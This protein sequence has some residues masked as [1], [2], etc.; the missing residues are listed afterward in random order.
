MYLYGITYLFDL[1]KALFTTLYYTIYF[2]AILYAICKTKNKKKKRL[3]IM[4]TLLH[5]YYKNQF[6]FSSL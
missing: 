5:I 1:L 2:N 6:I 3:L 4:H